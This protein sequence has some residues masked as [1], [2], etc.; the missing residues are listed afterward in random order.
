M[1][2]LVL[3]L[4]AFSCLSCSNSAG[5][6]KVSSAKD[7]GRTN[8]TEHS[9]TQNRLEK[10]RQGTRA[11]RGEQL[12]ERSKQPDDQ[13]KKVILQYRMALDAV[14]PSSFVLV[15]EKSISTPIRI[16][17]DLPNAQLKEKLA[18]DTLIR[19]LEKKEIN[20][21]EFECRA[22]QLPTDELRVLTVPRPTKKGQERLEE[23]H[24]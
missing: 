24:R 3:I 12:N 23:Y 13:T 19:E 10:Q 4:L 9:E 11:E 21:V 20:G 15:H 16:K 22:E 2:T 17:W 7:V 6:E 5:R 8:A 14:F 1:K 18:F